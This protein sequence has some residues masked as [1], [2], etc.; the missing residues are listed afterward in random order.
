MGRK[1][2][3]LVKSQ[4]G[5]V[6]TH[7][8]LWIPRA[9]SGLSLRGLSPRPCPARATLVHERGSLGPQMSPPGPAAAVAQL[10]AAGG[11]GRSAG[12]DAPAAGTT[13]PASRAQAHHCSRRPPREHPELAWALQS[14]APRPKKGMRKAPGRAGGEG[15]GRARHPPAR[16]SPGLGGRCGGTPGSVRH[17]RESAGA[18]GDVVTLRTP[19]WTDFPPVPEAR[20]EKSRLNAAAGLQAG[21]GGGAQSR[22]PLHSRPARST[23]PPAL[24][25]P[26]AGYRGPTLPFVFPPEQM[27]CDPCSILAVKIKGASTLFR[28]CN[29]C[30]PD[31][32]NPTSYFCFCF[33]FL[34]TSQ[35][36]I[37]RWANPSVHI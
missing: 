29:S 2:T 32:I 27:C 26:R 1:L 14:E 22:G 24:Q 4:T 21:T 35:P 18:G 15:V 36:L 20:R 17:L 12:R 16:R 10:R 25:E 3:T 23:P 30:S 37:I 31:L 28:N 6:R 7:H 9:A 13:P 11:S 33:V 19:I 5:L 34:A 8:K